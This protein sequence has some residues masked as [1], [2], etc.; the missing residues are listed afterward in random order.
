[1]DFQNLALTRYSCR[2]FKADVLSRET[3]LSIIE[4]A[5]LAPSAVNKQPWQVTIF[6]NPERIKALSACYSR[7]WFKTAP[8]VLLVCANLHESWVRQS[9][10]KNHAEI[11][12][13]IFIDHLTLAAADK[14]IGTCW[15]CN[16]DVKE[17]VSQ[18]NL[19][20]NIVPVALIPM[21]Y[22]A[23]EGIPEKKRKNINEF[24]KW[25]NES[26]NS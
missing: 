2:N 8:A 16:F 11:D 26:K 12:A 19:P 4:T 7:D 20:E 24:I 21:G 22:P 17:L 3:I 1:M 10:S 23:N 25:D 6:N 14:G 15:V 5:S 9:D 18:L 13:A